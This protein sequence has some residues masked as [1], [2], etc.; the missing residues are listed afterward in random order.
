[1]T[2]TLLLEEVQQPLGVAALALLEHL[3]VP[4]DLLLALASVK[5]DTTT[6]QT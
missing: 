3:L 2:K 1:M 6:K 5:P 4:G